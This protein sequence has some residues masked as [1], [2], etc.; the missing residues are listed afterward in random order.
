MPYYRGSYNGRPKRR[1]ASSGKRRS[2]AASRSSPRGGTMKLVIEHRTVGAA[3][4]PELYGNA[5]PRG[6]VKAK[7]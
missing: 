1:A 3:Q 2:S 7:L 4:R 5:V 6:S